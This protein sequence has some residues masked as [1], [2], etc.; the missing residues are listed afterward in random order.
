MGQSEVNVTVIARNENLTSEPSE[1]INF[2]ILSKPTIEL[3]GDEPEVIKLET[4]SIAM[5]ITAPTIYI[6]GDYL[7]WDAVEGATDYRYFYSDAN[8][9]VWNTRISGHFTK[10]SL[11]QIT[12]KL[13]SGTTT[14]IYMQ[15]LNVSDASSLDVNACSEA[16]NTVTYTVP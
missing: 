15:A 14:T 11:Q 5:S 9:V 3:M 4:P 10:Y 1:S 7:C 13:E 6:D 16:S 12:N 2:K 8:G